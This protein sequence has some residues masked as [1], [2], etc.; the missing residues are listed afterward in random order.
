[1][2]LPLHMK[3][4]R[5]TEPGGPQVLSLQEE[6]RPESQTGEVLV[7]VAAAG[8]NRPDI[9]LDQLHLPVFALQKGR[10]YLQ[11]NLGP[12]QHRGVTCLRDPR[13]HCVTN[14]G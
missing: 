7:H 14:G 3:V 1:M 6:P 5:I 13:Q 8:V 4:V 2:R 11:T 9:Q 10:H 12:F